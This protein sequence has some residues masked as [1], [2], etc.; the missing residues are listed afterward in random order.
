MNEQQINGTITSMAQASSPGLLLLNANITDADPTNLDRILAI[1]N[2]NNNNSNSNNNNHNN[3]QFLWFYH[4]GYGTI[5][6]CFYR[7]LRVQR[8]INN[9]GG[10]DQ[11][12]NQDQDGY[13]FTVEK[14][15]RLIGVKSISIETYRREN[16]VDTQTEDPYNEIRISNHIRR[17]MRQNAHVITEN[18]IIIPIGSV[19]NQTQEDI[20]GDHW[21]F[22][23][24]YQ[25]AN[26]GDLFEA[27]VER[28]VFN[29][30][31]DVNAVRNLFRQMVR[32]IHY[33]HNDVHVFH[34]DL[35]VENFVLHRNED[36]EDNSLIYIIL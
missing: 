7:A 36:E 13:T 22:Y 14:P 17:N 18:G 31:R 33:L 2:N 21:G 23:I 30:G 34:R 16:E 9:G 11:G 4:Q 3:A 1:L 28:D 29:G 15:H 26:G 19:H 24:L 20:G 25:Y 35:S 27:V 5:Y 32:A 10:E 12:Q 8:I 6:G